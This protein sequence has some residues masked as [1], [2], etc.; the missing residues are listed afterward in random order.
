M[1]DISD[2]IGL[3]ASSTGV[4]TMIFLVGYFVSLALG[5]LNKV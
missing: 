3:I 2:Y 1:A 5:L 4:F